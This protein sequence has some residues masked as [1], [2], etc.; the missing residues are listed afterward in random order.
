[1]DEFA[2]AYMMPWTQYPVTAGLLCAVL[3]VFGLLSFIFNKRGRYRARKALAFQHNCSPAPCRQQSGFLG[4]LD[5]LLDSYRHKSQH[6]YLESLQRNFSRYGRTYTSCIMGMNRLVTI[7]HA[8]I[9][10]ILKT[11]AEDFIARPARHHA[12]NNLVGPGVLTSDGAQWKFHRMMMKPSFDRRRLED[13]T[14]YEEYFQRLRKHLPAEHR[15]VDLQDLFFKFTLDLTTGHLFGSSSNTLSSQDTSTAGNQLAGAFD[16]SQR[17]AVHRFALGWLNWLVPQP[18]YWLDTRRVR[19]FADRYIA[20]ALRCQKASTDQHED[21]SSSTFLHSLATQSHSYDDVRSGTLHMLVA[22]RDST[23]SLLS[24]LW[25]CLAR[26]QRVWSKLKQEISMLDG[27]TPETSEELKRMPYLR[28]CINECKPRSLKLL[29]ESTANLSGALRCHPAIPWSLRAAARDTV[30]PSGGGLDQNAPILVPA[31]T[32]VLVPFYCLHRDPQFWGED[33]NDF[34]PERWESAK[35]GWAYLPFLAG[36]RMCLGYQFAINT[37]SYVTIRL[38]QCLEKV[39]P[40]S[41]TPWRE[42]LGL[43]MASADGVKVFVEAL[44]GIKVS[45]KQAVEATQHKA[46]VEGNAHVVLIE[47]CNNGAGEYF[48]S[49]G[50]TGSNDIL[51]HCRMTFSLIY[52][53]P[54]VA[55]KASAIALLQIFGSNEFYFQRN[56]A[57]PTF[58]FAPSPNVDTLYGAVMVDLSRHDLVLSIPPVDAGRYWDFA[59]TDPYGNNFENI[60]SVTK[61]TPGQYLIRHAACHSQET[62]H[63]PVGNLSHYDA[64]IDVPTVYAILNN[65]IRTQNK[66]VSCLASTPIP[67]LSVDLLNTTGTFTQSTAQDLE[68]IARV[69]QHNPPIIQNDSWR[70]K[71]LLRSASLYDGHYHPPEDVNLTLADT[72]ATEAIDA[73]ASSPQNILELGNDWYTDAL[74]IA[75]NFGTNYFYRAY[76]AVALFLQLTP[77][78][79]LYPRHRKYYSQ[80]FSL[81]SNRSLLFTFSDIPRVT[82]GGFWSLTAYNENYTLIDNAIDR[83]SVGSRDTLRFLDG[84]V[85]R[86]VP[87]ANRSTCSRSFQVLLQASDEPPP[88]NWTSNW[89]PSPAGGGIINFNLRFYAPSSA[90][91]DETYQ[92]P[93]IKEIAAICA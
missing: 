84:S 24:N 54:V 33:A 26:D 41:E 37:A 11:K 40:V 8:N 5:I 82:E 43:S 14:M 68:L 87:S 6:R 75:G 31:G 64:I 66:S 86:P 34:F 17:A 90:L 65:S 63:A 18:G 93:I 71:S 79:A 28:A 20:L 89:L 36:P 30:L 48:V 69:A 3:L 29:H 15:E 62:N 52:G 51:S 91:T 60:G 57:T 92:Y 85:N 73:A 13:L 81:D 50:R 44:E 61:S 16:R 23:A 32:S 88:V 22:G 25:F 67:E 83:Y 39:T 76:I 27:D 78:Q 42:E 2:L 12:L 1:M 21:T 4:G 46:N 49:T 38:M 77:D 74:S 58:S 59:F 35:P 47:H 53:S 70:V 9:E 10:A 72:R 80:N 19:Q 45:W 7:E 56:F 55:W